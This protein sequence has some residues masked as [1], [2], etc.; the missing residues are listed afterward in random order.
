MINR[1]FSLFKWQVWLD[2][3][4]PAVPNSDLTALVFIIIFNF[5]KQ[6]YHISIPLWF[7]LHFSNVGWHTIGSRC[8]ILFHIPNTFSNLYLV[9]S[10]TSSSIWTGNWIC[11]RL[12]VD[13]WVQWLMLVLSK[14]RN[15]V[16]DSLLSPKNR[17]SPSFRDVFFCSYLEFRTMD[18]VH[19]TQWLW[20]WLLF[21]RMEQ[22]SCLTSW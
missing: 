1:Q 6:V 14:G 12:Q 21:D 11:F 16:G 3:C 13:H 5:I 15:R 18:K 7:V 9:K 2:Y 20:I 17:N 22:S 10:V 8:I 19:K 4:S